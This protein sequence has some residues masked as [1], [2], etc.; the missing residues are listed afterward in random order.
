MNQKVIK[1]I[2]LDMGNVLL[3]Y[4]PHVILNQVCETEKE[5]QLILSE[6]FEGEE[7]IMGDR[8]NITNEQRYDLV[9]ER[10]PRELHPKLKECVLHWDICMKPIDGA[11]EFCSRCRA[12]GYGLYVLSNACN[13]FY[14]YFPQH[15]AMDSFDGVM[16][17]STVHLIKPDVRIYELLCSTYRLKPQECV[18]IDDRP[19]NVEAAK[20]IGME[21]IVFTGD[22][23]VVEDYLKEK[24]F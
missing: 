24:S 6:L 22:Y 5:K 12:E 13:H 15:Y 9:K 4:D 16:V 10:L 3:S 2:V 1:N 7:W 23:A 19:E 11:K 8:G 14:D 17:S 20:G 21:G 18:F